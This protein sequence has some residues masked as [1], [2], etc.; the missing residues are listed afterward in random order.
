MSYER[1]VVYALEYMPGGTL[2]ELYQEVGGVSDQ[3]R[4]AIFKQICSGVAVS[5]GGELTCEIFLTMMNCIV[6]A[7]AQHRASRP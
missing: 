4:L 6:S 5:G 7:R 1:T 3:E 2:E